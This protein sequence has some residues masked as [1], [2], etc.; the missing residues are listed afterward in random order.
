MKDNIINKCEISSL[1]IVW[2]RLQT[3]CSTTSKILASNSVTD[4]TLFV[5]QEY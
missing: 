3:G 1:K 4:M 2:R 5:G